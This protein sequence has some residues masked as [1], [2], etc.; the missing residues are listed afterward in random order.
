M[1][2]FA[3]DLRRLRPAKS[4]QRDLF[5]Q[6]SPVV[7]LGQQL[8]FLKSRV[9]STLAD[10]LNLRP[11]ILPDGFEQRTPYGS[12]YVSSQCYDPGHYHG[13]VR[14]DR[15]SCADLELLVSVMRHNVRVPERDALVFLD[16]ETT[17]IQGG[18]G[19]CPFLVGLGFFHGDEWHI[20]QFFIRDFDEE[21]SM[22]HALREQLSRFSL[23][24][25]YNGASFDIPLLESRFV[26]AR[27]DNPFEGMTHLDMLTSSRRLWR[28]GYGS[29]RLASLEARVAA[30]M[31]GQDVPGSA[32]PR[33]Y[34]DYLRGRQS[35]V[36]RGVFTH[37]VHD[38]ASLAAL[39]VCACDSIASPPAA[40][41]EPLNLFSL[42]K[43]FEHTSEW[44]KAMAFYEC[45]VQ[46]GLPAPLDRKARES[47]IL[48]FRR[49]GDHE[50]SLAMS[51]QLMQ[52]ED[53]SFIAYEGAAMYYERIG[54]NAPRALEIIEAGLSRLGDTRPSMRWRSSLL[55][56]RDRLRQI[57]IL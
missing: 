48:L 57:T 10:C 40:F 18:T 5:A 22:L 31:R 56:R 17:G 38:V 23:V 34:F 27:L 1:P 45:A 4:T 55:A 2:D 36:L 43:V 42:A 46:G 7:S 50:R 30:F 54:R 19:T 3:K 44:K 21:H 15:F 41:D 33:A 9:T 20:Q 16:T 39:T 13:K 25:T 53:F 37:N 35:P 29:C 51:E 47:L 12:H 24:I 28:N 26:L 6:E 14:L 52:A 49:A 11:A 8:Q 32:I